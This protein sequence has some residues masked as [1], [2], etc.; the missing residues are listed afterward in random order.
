VAFHFRLGAFD[1]ATMIGSSRLND[2]QVWSTTANRDMAAVQSEFTVA[3][4]KITRLRLALRRGN[5][6]Q[7]HYYFFSS[8]NGE[9]RTG[10]D[11][12]AAARAIGRMQ[13]IFMLEAS[14]DN[15]VT[16]TPVRWK[17]ANTNFLNRFPP[18]LTFDRT[19]NIRLW[20]T[21][22]PFSRHQLQVASSPLGPWS[23]FGAEFV[24]PNLEP[25]EI[26]D[27]GTD[28]IRFYRT[29]SP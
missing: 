20:V 26:T 3:G 17:S 25:L 29:I 24:L 5:S 21:G 15:G 10:T 9:A 14:T 6:T 7:R 11:G 19:P 13:I 23:D 22:L 27:L 1:S 4:G 16:Y 12:G 18:Q 2:A 8:I 28:P